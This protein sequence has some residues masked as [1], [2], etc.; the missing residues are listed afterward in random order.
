[1]VFLKRYAHG[2]LTVVA[3]ITSFS[4]LSCESMRRAEHADGILDFVMLAAGR[5]QPD[6]TLIERATT[7][8]GEI[9][10]ARAVAAGDGVLVRGSIKK[11]T[12]AGWVSA[13]YSHVDIIVL[14][15]KRKITQAKTT[16]FSPPNVPATMRGIEGRSHYSAIIR[17]PAPGST[18][19]IRFH[20]VPRKECQFD[21]PASRGVYLAEPSVGEG[22]VSPVTRP[23]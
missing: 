23:T 22:G 3:L 8:A 17:Q 10:T 15:P 11:R 5:A 4:F 1:M 16:A 20:N 12:G 18:I 7:G 19:S 6:V 9:A 21:Q 14:N 13:V 2:W